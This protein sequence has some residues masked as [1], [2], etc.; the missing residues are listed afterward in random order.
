M[1]R[2]NLSVG[3]N[4]DIDLLYSGVLQNSQNVSVSVHKGDL[5][6]VYTTPD[7]SVAP[8]TVSNAT[9]VR[10]I[11]NGEL[12]EVDSD[13]SCTIS[14]SASSGYSYYYGVIKVLA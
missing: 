6:F 10:T 4:I 3:A 2:A 5:I 7:H 12:F 14:G 13:G 8:A 9:S 1:I 11:S